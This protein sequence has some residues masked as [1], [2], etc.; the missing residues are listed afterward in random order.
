MLGENQCRIGVAALLDPAYSLKSR[1]LPLRTINHEVHYSHETP[2]DLRKRNTAR[3][4]SSS[5]ARRQGAGRL[6]I[7]IAKQ[8]STLFRAS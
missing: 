6:P 8:T 5:A 2:E 4:R 3:C 7:V 1:R